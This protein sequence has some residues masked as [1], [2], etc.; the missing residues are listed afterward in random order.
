MRT[1]IL[2]KNMDGFYGVL[3]CPKCRKVIFLKE[4]P[5]KDQKKYYIY[6][7]CEC[8]ENLEWLDIETAKVE[9]EI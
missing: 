6:K 3:Q 7:C 8:L 1:N 4:N 5:P 2:F 9:I